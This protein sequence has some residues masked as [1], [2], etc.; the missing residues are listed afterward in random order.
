MHHTLPI[1]NN[2]LTEL[3]A[4]DKKLFQDRFKKPQEK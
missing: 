1:L 3:E 4:Y 2:L